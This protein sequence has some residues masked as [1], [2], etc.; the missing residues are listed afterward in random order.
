[1]FGKLKQTMIAALASVFVMTSMA[2]QQVTT[3][4]KKTPDKPNIVMFLCDDQDITLGGWSPMTQ[5]TAV[6]NT[7]GV[8]AK[9]W[10]IHT[11][12]CC[13]SRAEFLSGRY[14]HNVR[15][16]TSSGGCMH[17]NESK[18]NPVSFMYYLNQAGY[19]VGYFGKHMNSCPKEAPPGFD[20]PD[21]YWFANGGGSDSEPGG[22][23]NA[24]FNDQKST[25]KGN[26]NGEFAG[27][28]TSIIANKSMT[29]V[30]KVAAL[31]KPFFVQV[32]PKAPHVPATPALWYATEFADKEAP[33]T[34]N[35]NASSELLQD[36]HWLIAQQGPITESQAVTIDELFR[37]R[38]RTLLSVDDA[39]AALVATIED[40][41]LIDSTY[42]FS[43][44]DH[45]YQLGQLRLPSC[46]L[47]V[48]ENDIR[49]PMV[50]R[51][52]GITAGSTFD[53]PASNVDVGPTVLGLAGLSASTMDGKSIVPLL[54]NA[55]DP[56]VLPST[57]RHL[58]ANAHVSN[59]TWREFHFVEYY[60]LGNVERTGHLV[61]DINSNTYRAVRFVG[62]TSSVGNLL[63]AEF[64]ALSDYSFNNVSFREMYDLDEDPWQLHNIYATA[65]ASLK[66]KLKAALDSQ[67]ACVG[68]SCV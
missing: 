13:P 28:T 67:Y 34:P 45:G 12:V 42:F 33:R 48:Y 54:L 68:T 40:L 49:I 11:P 37:D 23:L 20:C 9:N 39:I 21:C 7:Q 8:T 22:Y 60:S 31:G 29:W 51:G 35:Y 5:A 64:T 43:T 58:I 24:T 47:N 52:P 30:R 63:Y 41:G 38:W 32:A 17:V 61:D 59:T 4:A 18:V 56:K 36:H 44:S 15:E 57:Q 1:M 66:Q 19:N 25:Y 46:K 6:L 2:S 65:D 14:F 26:T 53:F 16:T 50:I 62:P 27:Y 3:L 10:F 55:S